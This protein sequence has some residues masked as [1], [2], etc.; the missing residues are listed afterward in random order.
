MNKILYALKQALKQIRRNK[1]MSITSTFAITAMML[2]LGMFLMIIINVNA[3]TELVKKD[4]NNIEIFFKDEV[5]MTKI[6]QI[7]KDISSWVEVKDATIRTKQEAMEVMK[8]RWGKNGKLLDGL[9]ENPLPNSVVVTV[10]NIKDADAVALKAESVEGM[11]DINYYKSTV[12]KLIK[13]TDGLQL[14]GIII[15][16]FLIVVAVVVVSNTIKLTVLNRKDEITIMR[17][18]GATNW[19]VRAPFFLEGIIIGITSAIISS[20]LV[21]VVY[22]GVTKLISDEF[23]TI[24]AIKLVPESFVTINL[25]WIFIALGVSIGSSGSIISMR[26]FLDND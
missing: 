18:M 23:K 24:L 12:D 6:E 16:I 4:Y 10:A 17:D 2:I 1:G 25:I 14:A 26:R 9:D 20:A 13:F 7:Q 8:E 11:E 21:S 3:T 19:F 15:M 5:E 22:A